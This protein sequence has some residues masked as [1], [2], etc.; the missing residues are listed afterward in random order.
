MENLTNAMQF[1]MLGFHVFLCNFTNKS[2]TTFALNSELA[3]IIHQFDKNI[4]LR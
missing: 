4:F 2:V 1:F 3:K